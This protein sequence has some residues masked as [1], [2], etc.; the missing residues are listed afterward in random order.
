MAPSKSDIIAAHTLGNSLANFQDIYDTIIVE[1]QEEHAKVTEKRLLQLLTALQ[2][3]PICFELPSRRRGTLFGDIV[4]LLSAVNSGQFDINSLHPLLKAI[5]DGEPDEIIWDK[6]YEAVTEST[7]PPKPALPFHQTPLSRNTSSIANSSEYRK[8]FDAVLKE[9]LDSL[10]VGVPEVYDKLFENVQGLELAAGAVLD[11]CKGG[12]DPL[13]REGTGWRGWP[14]GAKERDVLAW[15]TEKISEFIQLFEEHAPDQDIQLH[16]RDTKCHWSHILIPG[17]LKNDPKYDKRS[18]AWLDLARYVREVMA[19]RDLPS[20]DSAIQGSRRFVLGFTLCGSNMRLWLFDRLGGIASETFDINEDGFR[21]VSIILGFLQMNQQQLGYDPTILTAADGARYIEIERNGEAERLIIDEQIARA[22]SCVAGRGTICWRAHRE[23]DESN[24][25]LV[26]KDSWQYPEREEEGEL[27][28][29][30]MENG[31]INVA[32]YYHHETVKVDGVDDDIRNSVRRGLDITKAANYTPNTSRPPLSRGNSHTA[33]KDGSSNRKRSSTSIDPA[34]PATKSTVILLKAMI[35]CLDGYMSLYDKTGLIQS[36][37]SPNNLMISEDGRGFVIDLDLAVH[38][39]RVKA[40]EARLKTGTR[41]FMAIGVLWGKQQ[42]S[43]MH[44]LESFFWVLFWI[45]VHC[46]GP[47]KARVDTDYE[48][49]NYISMN[50]LT[51]LKVGIVG[52]EPMFL[53]KINR[54]F[55]PHYQPLVKYVNRLRRAVFPKDKPWEKEDV[56][57]PLQM[58][59]ILQDAVAD[60]GVVSGVE[61]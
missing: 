31:V 22:P 50:E 13:Y 53:E 12:E 36:D 44:D 57:L 28:R 35:D 20:E 39:D 29:E 60:P 34:L 24:T 2:A 33:R 26:I 9:E 27:L 11:K 23:G 14:E 52:V 41:A 51:V 21:F 6:V 3:N 47:A 59:R 38:K 18:M 5:R 16:S 17:E 48:K 32:G 19:P 58:E 43:F 8:D 54:D 40:S 42:H 49:W 61:E 4:W 15:V 1:G 10:Y 56:E 30:A 37:I 55:T 45:C 7:P 25:V 46:E